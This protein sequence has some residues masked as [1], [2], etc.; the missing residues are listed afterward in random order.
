MPFKT[1]AKKQRRKKK[2]KGKISVSSTSS[3]S[4]SFKSSSG[5]DKMMMENLISLQRVIVNL[6]VKLD[7]LADKISKLLELF[8]ISAKSLAERGI[9]YENY[10]GNKELSQKVNSLFEQNKTIAKG[11]TMM[12]ERGPE[13]SGMQE[14]GPSRA[15]M[16]SFPS[17][18]EVQPAP[19]KGML[20]LGGYQRSR[21]LGEP[22]SVTSGSNTKFKPFRET[23]M[24][25]A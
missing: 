10:K 18:Q 6:S 1:M 5:M 22:A 23:N 15:P 24:N 2:A 12:Y 20:E 13:S 17:Q 7:S 9:D 16:P 11:L 19:S 25:N 3:E 4:P 8:E 21:T 14:Q